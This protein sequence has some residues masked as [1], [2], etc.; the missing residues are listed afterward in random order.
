ML[1]HILESLQAHYSMV[2]K[3]SKLPYLFGRPVA[4]SWH[5]KKVQYF[6]LLEPKTVLTYNKIKFGRHFLIRRKWY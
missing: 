4:R 3:T 1:S 5:N 6:H 2:V